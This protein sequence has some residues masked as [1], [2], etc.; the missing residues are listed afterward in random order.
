M[1]KRI[2]SLL[3]TLAMCLS[4]LPASAVTAGAAQW[5]H[6]IRTTTE[7]TAAE[8]AEQAVQTALAPQTAAQPA[9]QTR[10]AILAGAGDTLG[11]NAAAKTYD[12]LYFGTYH[13]AEGDAGVP[14]LWRILDGKTSRG[15]NGLFLLSEEYYSVYF[16]YAPDKEDVKAI[17][18]NNWQD[19]YCYARAWCD[20]FAESDWFS[21][22]EKA[23]MLPTT[24]TY[25]NYH[26]TD[27][28]FYEI[29]DGYGVKLITDGGLN[30]E[31]VFFLAAS[32]YEDPSYGLTVTDSKQHYVLRSLVSGK[33]TMDDKSTYDSFVAVAVPGSGLQRWASYWMMYTGQKMIYEDTWVDR[34]FGMRDIFP[35]LTEEVYTYEYRKFNARPAMNLNGAKIVYTVAAD[36]S[37]RAAYGVPADYSGTEWKL[38]LSDGTTDFKAGTSLVTEGSAGSLTFGTD[39]GTVTVNHPAL[40]EGYDAVTA[41]LL[42]P[43]GNIICYGTINS[44]KSATASTVS[45]PAELPDGVYTLRVAA[46]KWNEAKKADF[47]TV[48]FETKVNVANEHYHLVCHD[49]KCTDGHEVEIWKPITSAAEL[50]AMQPDGYYF[51]VGN[52]TADE[53]VA[54]QGHLCL[55]GFALQGT[56]HTGE[57]FSLSDC[58]KKREQRTDVAELVIPAGTTFTTYGVQISS[59]KVGTNATLN[60]YHGL[61]DYCYA[62]VTELSA[63]AVI[64]IR[65]GKLAGPNDVYTGSSLTVPAGVTINLYDG[66]TAELNLQ[67]GATLNVYGGNPVRS[68]G[69]EGSTVNIRNG[70]IGGFGTARYPFK[71]ELNLYDGFQYLGDSAI[72]KPINI[73]GSLSRIPT[74]NSSGAGPHRLDLVDANGKV[75]A[76]QLTNGWSEHMAGKRFNDYFASDSAGFRNYLADDGEIYTKPVTHETG[77]HPICGVECTHG[78][79]HPALEWTVVTTWNEFL[80]LVQK[81]GTQNICLN[82]D[83]KNNYATERI[84]V[85][86]TINLCLHGYKLD[87]VRVIGGTGGHFVVENGAALNITDCAGGGV[88]T[89]GRAEKTDDIKQYAVGG[90]IRL[91][92]GATA[93]LYGGTIAES[94]ADLGGAVYVA[95]GA[96]FT[97]EGGTLDGNYAKGEGWNDTKKRNSKGGAVYLAG[98]RFILNGGLLKENNTVS[99]EY[100]NAEYYPKDSV[101]DGGG[102]VYIADGGYFE[103]NGTRHA[104]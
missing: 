18:H 31:K 50:K 70:W 23:I 35:F 17:T 52:I 72:T 40:G 6:P 42:D 89:N 24:K 104:D 92:T 46:E 39:G 84:S 71:S 26:S 43:Q 9:A 37:A 36:N 58:A 96:T 99:M 81:D 21:D 100:N 55:N 56:V 20:R 93:T 65:K 57:G 1:K 11:F 79:A 54:Y 78:G 91:K 29:D 82:S 60:V 45:I 48:P 14:Y 19:E 68:Y 69:D 73:C 101:Q 27:K 4:L 90:A 15:E 64:N 33:H 5:T 94:T 75:I 51:L 38:V 95:Q 102:A 2:V 7:Q 61:T 44:D 80:N 76:G 53:S 10:K 74:V 67:K 49:S 59:V 77:S 98:G 62:F 63:G 47:A 66:S 13:G 8:A 41:A 22:D 97:M 88:I 28:W 87:L 32:E 12:K 86:G 83:I 16:C 30:N 34:I 3:L 85:K 25:A 103:M